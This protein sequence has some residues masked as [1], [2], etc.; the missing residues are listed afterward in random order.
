MRKDYVGSEMASSCKSETEF[1]EEFW[2]RRWEEKGISES[3]SRS[4]SRREENKILLA[5]I[6]SMPNN[7]RMLDAG[8]GLGEW[9]VYLSDLGFET[10]GVDLS[11][12]AIEK[13]R[14]RFPRYHFH[15]GDIRKLPYKE[16]FF[17][18]YFSWGVFEHFE[19]GMRQCFDEARRVLAPDGVII[20]SVP[21]NNRRHMM[22]DNRP[23]E[24]VDTDFSRTKGFRTAKRFY[25][26]RLNEH[27]LERE[28][29]FG[30]F[31]ITK[32]ELI[33]KDEGASRL[34]QSLL[35]FLPGDF[36]HT[37]SKAIFSKVLPAKWIA[38]MIIASGKKR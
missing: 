9:V 30:G 11:Q 29:E 35:G 14:Y 7:I 15:A 13:L 25:Q 24:M 31:K 1:I 10:H 33:H 8:C 20:I 36:F 34:V 32:M 3:F 18:V 27:E 38:H 6:Q 4:I 16:H 17:N 5:S 12:K 19:N 22:N 21:Y 2:T 37:V 26:W 28:F 23:L